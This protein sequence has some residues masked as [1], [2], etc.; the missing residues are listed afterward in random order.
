M[1]GQRGDEL[2]ALG[3]QQGDAARDLGGKRWSIAQ[4][5]EGEIEHH[6]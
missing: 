6:P 4:Q 2:R 5:E 1:L 3:G